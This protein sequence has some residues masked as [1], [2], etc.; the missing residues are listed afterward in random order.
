MMKHYEQ[1]ARWGEKVYI[2]P[3]LSHQSLS[4]GKS[5]QQLQLRVKLNL[6]L[7][8]GRNVEIGAD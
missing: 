2:W 4:L 3:T 8:L 6:K 5:G 1:K 7:N